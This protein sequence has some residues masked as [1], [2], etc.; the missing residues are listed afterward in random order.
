MSL[1]DRLRPDPP[2]R[3]AARSRRRPPPSAQAAAAAATTATMA[4]LTGAA[5]A[6]LSWVAVVLPALL[7][8]A[9]SAQA[10]A[11]W[12]EAARV[13]TVLW[14]VVH[15]VQVLL[16]GGSVAFAPLGLTLVPI[17]LCWVAG[18][19]V[20]SGLDRADPHGHGVTAA[21]ARP[22]GDWR[23]PVATRWW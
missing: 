15:R 18:R 13:S 11:T 9:T 17:W 5:T 12:G 3:T 22:R 23:W 4:A 7:A 21:R 20:G 8:W 2:S 6:A 10:S 16:P 19:R 1:L 14:L